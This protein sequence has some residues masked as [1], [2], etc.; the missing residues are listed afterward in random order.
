[1][2]L[3]KAAEHVQP[4]AFGQL[5]D[6]D[7]DGVGDGGGDGV[8]P[9]QCKGA[10][11]LIRAWILA[12]DSGSNASVVVVMLPFNAIS[13]AAPPVPTPNMNSSGCILIALLTIKL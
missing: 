7:G 8:G 6:G 12:T 9:V 3:E 13:A 2:H 5:G 11:F 1:M 10:C 4:T